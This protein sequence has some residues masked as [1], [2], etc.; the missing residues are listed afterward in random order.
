MASYP[1][2]GRAQVYGYRV[3]GP[4]EPDAGHRFNPMKLLLDPYARAHIGD[5]RLGPGRVRLHHRRPG[6]GPFI[7]CA[8]QRALHAEIRRRRSRISTGMANPS[9][10]RSP[11]TGRFSMKPMCAATRS[12]I[13][14]PKS[15]CAE[16]TRDLAAR[17]CSI[18]EVASASPRSSCCRSTASST[19]IISCKSVSPIIGATTP[20]AFSRP[21]RVTPP[22][23]P[24]ACANS[25]RWCR[26]FMKPTSK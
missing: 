25:R 8:R 5:L 15:I 18:I 16:P 9:A 10:S 19:T 7:R 12:S 23:A 13:R 21:T 3:H 14:M 2:L 1:I 24:I 20:S 17:R 6:R 26:A 4:Y 22:T 11:G